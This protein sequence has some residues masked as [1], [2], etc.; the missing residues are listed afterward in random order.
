M[1]EKEIKSIINN[2]LDL[3][4]KKELQPKESYLTYDKSQEG[5][6]IVRTPKGIIYA[7]SYKIKNDKLFKEIHN[8][9]CVL[10]P[11]SQNDRMTIYI[12]GISG[13]GKTTFSRKICNEIEKI[14]GGKNIEKILISKKKSDENI[15]CLK[16]LTR[17]DIDKYMKNPIK[18]LRKY[19]NKIFIFD[20]VDTFP[21]K[22]MKHAV[23]NLIDSVLNT[24]RTTKNDCIITSHLINKGYFS[25]N[26]LNECPYITFFGNSGSDYA[27]SYYL[28][29]YLGYNKNLIHKLLSLPSRYVTIYKSHPQ[30]AIYENGC[31]IIDNKYK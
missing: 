1:S 12:C 27:I 29:T 19:K 21:N 3:Y 5:F 6:P 22:K 10:I 23:Y 24:G 4:L 13:A 17:I 9:E 8:T 11:N 30:I 2:Y 14:K 15:D 16:N 26:I 18:D 31:F 20:D 25:K 28:K 7:C